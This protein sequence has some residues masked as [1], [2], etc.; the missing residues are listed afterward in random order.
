MVKPEMFDTEDEGQALVVVPLRT[1]QDQWEKEASIQPET[2][3]LLQHLGDPA[4]RDVVIDL[5]HVPYFRSNSNLLQA[6]VVIWKHLRANGKTM[7]LCNVSEIGLTILD[8][9]KFNTL[10]PIFSSRHEALE[11]ISA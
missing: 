3:G 1:A 4:E 7:A 10:W 5:T 9:A 6:L 2:D 8:A 11:K